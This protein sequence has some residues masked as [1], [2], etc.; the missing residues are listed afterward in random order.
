[1]ATVRSSTAAICGVPSAFFATS[2]RYFP[3]RNDFV[4]RTKLSTT[5]AEF[6][7]VPSWNVTPDRTLMVHTV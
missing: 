1:M 4:W 7:G 6:S 2:A 5:A 3:V